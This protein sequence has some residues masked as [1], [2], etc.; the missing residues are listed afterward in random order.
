[1]G[2]ATGLLLQN[3][4]AARVVID[5]DGWVRLAFWVWPGGWAILDPIR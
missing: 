4:K 2:F 5:R 3:A 1:M